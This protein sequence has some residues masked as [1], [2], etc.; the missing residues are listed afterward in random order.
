MFKELLIPNAY[1]QALRNATGQVVDTTKAGAESGISSLVG[2][3]ARNIDNW[4]AGLVIIVIFWII[5]K[6]SASAAREAIMKKKGED[7]HESSLLLVERITIITILVIGIAIA[8][9]INGLN[10]TAIIGAL[11]L[12]IGFALKDIIGNFISG[13]IMLTQ[14][15]IRIGDLI[16][17]GDI[18]GTIVSID[19]RATV[20]QSV[21]GTEVVIPNQNMLSET[22]VSFS[23]NPYRRVEFIIG[24]DY[25]TDL[26]MVTSLIKEITDQDENIVSEP[27]SM[28]LVD[29]FG[30][31]AINI[32]VL[33]WI[34]SSNNW[35]KI[36]SN[37]ANRIKHAFD[38]LNI[39]IP[40]PIRTLKVD[41][42][43]RSLLKTYKS[44]ITGMVPEPPKT[45]NKERIISAAE[46]T[47]KM[48]NIPEK[49]G[50]EK[51]KPTEKLVSREVAE[52]RAE[53]SLESTQKTT[54]AIKT[55]EEV[56]AP[57]THM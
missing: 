25:G 34:E 48:T 26:P 35:M 33:F 22:L 30:D 4:I 46:S 57:P 49:I 28:V 31:S 37:L 50:F 41:E 44:A 24:V 12:G 10:F 38:D 36:R 14:D 55:E 15:R 32:K 1:A 6:M 53:E 51:P 3:V 29:A 56:K 52:E 13:V 23:T 5:A 47:K 20:L 39:N 21:D 2:I 54:E 18:L 17:I 11:S 45:P 8:F 16:K 40:F 19:V 7:V 27:E 43:D 9:A 42:D